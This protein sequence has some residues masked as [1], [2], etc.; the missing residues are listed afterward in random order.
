[1]ALPADRLV[2]WQLRR[3]LWLLVLLS[4]LAALLP[5]A[6][7]HAGDGSDPRVRD[8]HDEAPKALT[9]VPH[10]S[11]SA[12][13]EAAFNP[14]GLYLSEGISYQ[15]PYRHDAGLKETSSSWEAG[16]NVGT[17]PS[18]FQP[19]LYLEWMPALF[20]TARLEYDPYW[21]FGRHHGS[22][23]FSSAQDH[24]GDPELRAREGT[25]DAGTGS[26]L[27]IQPT[28]QFKIGDI[29]VRNQSDLARYR[30]PGPGPYY[31]AQEYDTLLRNN[32]WLFAN[33][34]QVLKEIRFAGGIMFIGPYYEVVQGTPGT[35]LRRQAGILFYSEKSRQNA[36]E[37][38]Y[39]YVAQIGYDLTDQN[40]EGQ[41]FFLI[42]LGF[43]SE[44]R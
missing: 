29:A 5:A 22:L 44:L 15:D 38:G 39:H 7:A 42:G 37:H 17:S 20:V 3:T 18:Y 23:S 30:F 10:W 43:S 28:L 13:A 32:G 25:E 4:A 21:Y 34:T 31:L 8:D 19:S 16:A 2:C 11:Q 40:R 12:D 36:A 9:P 33:R 24:F 27:F 41:V 26:R 14:R 6:R 35:R 1:M